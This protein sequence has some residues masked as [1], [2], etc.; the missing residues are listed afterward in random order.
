MNKVSN[1]M[2]DSIL[3]KMVVD[4][5]IESSLNLLLNDKYVTSLLKTHP[6]VEIEDISVNSSKHSDDSGIETNYVVA[7]KYTLYQEFS[8]VGKVA[9]INIVLDKNNIVG[10][11]ITTGTG[12]KICDNIA[13]QMQ[14][15]I[16][17]NL[18]K[19]EIK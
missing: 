4:K 17:N 19:D 9:K 16:V 12:R 11:P 14:I 6:N 5:Y 18:Y 1:T 7:V 8:N 15:S 2:T 13:N 3:R 10:T